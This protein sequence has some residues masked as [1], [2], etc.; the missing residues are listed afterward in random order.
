MKNVQKFYDFI[1]WGERPL[2]KSLTEGL[3]LESEKYR[4]K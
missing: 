4:I 2:D 3:F 1:S